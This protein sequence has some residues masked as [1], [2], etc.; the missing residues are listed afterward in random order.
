MTAKIG[1]P[2]LRLIRVRIKNILL[3]DLASG[4]VREL[5][6]NELLELKK[7]Q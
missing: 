7:Q 4:Q 3:G 5:S 2:T 1:H 6:E